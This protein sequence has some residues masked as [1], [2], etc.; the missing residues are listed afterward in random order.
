MIA[1]IQTTYFKMLRKQ[2]IYLEPEIFS[3]KEIDLVTTFLNYFPTV[4]ENFIKTFL[5][6]QFSV[7][8]GK[9]SMFD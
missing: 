2:G 4:D 1:T 5:T 6:F 7:Y 8:A 9:D 3:P